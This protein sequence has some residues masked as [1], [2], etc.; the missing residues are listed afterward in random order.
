LLVGILSPGCNRNGN[1]APQGEKEQ[2]VRRPRKETTNAEITETAPPLKAEGNG[3][4]TLEV[5]ASQLSQAIQRTKFAIGDKTPRYDLN[6][7][8]VDVRDEMIF[9]VATDGARMSVVELGSAG[10]SDK[11]EPLSMLIPKEGLQ[12]IESTGNGSNRDCELAIDDSAI[13]VTVGEQITRLPLQSPRYPDWQA[14]LP[15]T[16]Q[17]QAIRLTLDPLLASL[18]K[19]TPTEAGEPIVTWSFA[20]DNLRLSCQTSGGSTSSAEVPISHRG[21]VL[22]TRLNSHLVIPFLRLVGTGDQLTVYVKDDK[23]GVV[24]SAGDKWRYVVMPVAAD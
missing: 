15:D 22:T 21:E 9:F 12:I 19:A 17:M 7:V 8:V 1:T 16:T 14:F 13:Q 2:H 11:G 3:S 5:P 10:R 23:S 4:V 6:G 20:R 18:V 24:F